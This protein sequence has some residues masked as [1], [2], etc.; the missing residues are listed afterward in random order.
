MG[1]REEK[2]AAPPR[3]SLEYPCEFVLEVKHNGVVV[4][5]ILIQMGGMSHQYIKGSME[6]NLWITN[7]HPSDDEIK[8]IE[9]RV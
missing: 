7:L 6:G 4:G 5:E 1:S 2:V 9:Q 3:I 8:T